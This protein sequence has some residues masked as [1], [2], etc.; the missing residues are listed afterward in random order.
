MLFMF[1][2]EYS[3]QSNIS[4][5]VNQTLLASI[6]AYIDEDHTLWEEN[7]H[8]IA[9]ALRNVVH[10]STKFGEYFHPIK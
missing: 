7:I 8:Q 9:S 4:E 5:R 6:R 3:P 2:L 10:E 1:S